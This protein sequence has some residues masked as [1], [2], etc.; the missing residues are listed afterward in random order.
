MAQSTEWD[1]PGAC[2]GS[3]IFNIF[4]NDL[5]DATECMF[6]KCANETKVS[7]TAGTSEGRIRI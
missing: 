4:S 5:E 6:S 3:D 1:S 2:A 7:G